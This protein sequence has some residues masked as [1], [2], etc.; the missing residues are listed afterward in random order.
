MHHKG[1]EDLAYWDIINNKLNTIY[2]ARYCNILIGIYLSRTLLFPRVRL[3]LQLLFLSRHLINNLHVIVVVR[4]NSWRSTW[5]WRQIDTNYA[6]EDRI[7]YV[8][9]N[10]PSPRKNVNKQP[11]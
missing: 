9:L 10:W 2:K 6:I 5:K 4:G 7:I 11:V 8:A 3:H 1:W